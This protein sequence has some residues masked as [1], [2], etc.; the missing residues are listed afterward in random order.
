M[1]FFD[2][3]SP[4][5]LGLDQVVLSWRANIYNMLSLIPTFGAEDVNAHFDVID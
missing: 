1:E 2:A 5:R 3:A 4:K